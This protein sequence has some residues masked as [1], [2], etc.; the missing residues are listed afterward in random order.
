M[1]CVQTEKEDRGQQILAYLPTMLAAVKGHCG[2]F[3]PGW[4]VNV[5]GGS[6][7]YT[8]DEH[9]QALALIREMIPE[10]VI[11]VEFDTPPDHDPIVYDG[12]SV[13][14]G[15]E[16]EWYYT[17]GHGRLVDVIGLRMCYEWLAD[18]HVWLNG[19]GGVVCRLQGL[20]AMPT[21]WP[22]GSQVEP[23]IL[24]NCAGPDY[25]VHKVVIPLEYAAFTRM[26]TSAKREY[27]LL[28]QAMIPTLVGWG[29]G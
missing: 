16:A 11:L 25:G 23:G 1:L 12:R 14:P 17:H 27:R 21:Q 2:A 6:S 22:D 28:A 7:A 18:P 26:L 24:A 8:A 4:E 13:P 20:F 29:E 10:A 19:V 3:F 15:E 5:S 9:G